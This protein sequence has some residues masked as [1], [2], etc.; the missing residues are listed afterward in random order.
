MSTGADCRFFEK[1]PRKWFYKLQRWPYGETP[2]YDTFGPFGTFYEAHK[3]LHAK[4]ANPGGYFTEPLPGCKHD[5][6]RKREFVVGKETHD[7]DRCGDHV[8]AAT[9]ARLIAG[10]AKELQPEVEPP[11]EPKLNF[12]GFKGLFR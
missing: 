11:F 5:L 4:H 2:D 3:H 9:A 10:G 1:E 7:C 6:L 8:D 12:F